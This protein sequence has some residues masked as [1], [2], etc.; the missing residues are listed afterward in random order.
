MSNMIILFEEI[1]FMKNRIIEI[2]LN[3]LN[4]YAKYR[5]DEVKE[6]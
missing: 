1:V 3:N 5:H 4:I 2:K 6:H